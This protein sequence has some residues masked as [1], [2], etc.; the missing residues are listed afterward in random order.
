M[1][2]LYEVDS[3]LGQLFSEMSTISSTLLDI[4]SFLYY[5]WKQIADFEINIHY[6]T[7]TA[8]HIYH[9]I[10]LIQHLQHAA[11]VHGFSNDNR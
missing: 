1:N 6:T 11:D 10:L 8:L 3:A 7:C 9:S 2:S 5:C 4:N